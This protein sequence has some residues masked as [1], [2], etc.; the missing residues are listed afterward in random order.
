MEWRLQQT[1]SV[2]DIYPQNTKLL[3]IQPNTTRNMRREYAWEYIKERTVGM[4]ECVEV[5]NYVIMDERSR[6]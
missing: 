2:N 4:C 6:R 1:L 5:T 3:F